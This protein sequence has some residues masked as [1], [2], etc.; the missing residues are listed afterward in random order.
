MVTIKILGAGCP[1][2]NRLE[3]EVNAAL[4]ESQIEYEVVKLTDAVDFMA[5]RIMRLPGLVMNESVLAVGRIPKR[6]QIL[7]WAQQ[8][9]SD[10]Y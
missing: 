7:E 3:Q 6:P 4:A 5:Y 9:Q 8:F 10:G 2:C 1:K